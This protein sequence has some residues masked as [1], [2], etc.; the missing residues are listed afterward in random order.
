MTAASLLREAMWS[1]T[2]ELHSKLPIDYVAYSDDYLGRFA[3]S[4]DDFHGSR[5]A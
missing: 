2:Q 3:R 4:L 5:A 1:L